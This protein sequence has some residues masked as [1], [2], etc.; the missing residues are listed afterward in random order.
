MIISGNTVITGK[1]AEDLGKLM[2]VI[3]FTAWEAGIVYGVRQLVSIILNNVTPK[4]FKD[5]YSNKG[6][7]EYMKWKKLQ[8]AF[9]QVLF[10]VPEETPG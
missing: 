8:R 1:A 5:I 10:A 7:K 2:V 9:L 4:E 3:F 6:A